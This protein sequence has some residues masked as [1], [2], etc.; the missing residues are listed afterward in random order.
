MTTGPAAA[1]SFSY[2]VSLGFVPAVQ[3]LLDE[4]FQTWSYA[5][6][7]PEKV[8]IFVTTHWLQLCGMNLDQSSSLG[9]IEGEASTLGSEGLTHN[10]AERIQVMR[11]VQPQY[12]LVTI[13]VSS[14][15]EN[16]ASQTS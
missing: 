13:P 2:Q 14:R 12:S 9:L 10:V 7:Q 1:L 3:N 11:N 5:I 8:I 6:L 4:N 16:L 15:R